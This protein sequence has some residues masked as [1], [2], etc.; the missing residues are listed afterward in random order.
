MGERREIVSRLSLFICATVG[1]GRMTVTVRPE[2]DF[3]TLFGDDDLHHDAIHGNTGWIESI[4]SA[5]V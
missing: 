2:V 1:A 4:G 5:K 3:L